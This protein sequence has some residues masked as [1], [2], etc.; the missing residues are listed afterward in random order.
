MTITVGKGQR[1]RKALRGSVTC[2]LDCKVRV[3]ATISIKRAN[4]VFKTRRVKLELLAN[5]KESFGLKFSRYAAKAIQRLAK[6]R[7]RL[8]VTI[9]AVGKDV[10]G[11]PVGA[12]R[13]VRVRR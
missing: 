6:G 10:A 5:Q 11:V 8:K 7:G 13:T 3:G 1:L 12:Q 9:A 4:R 2:E